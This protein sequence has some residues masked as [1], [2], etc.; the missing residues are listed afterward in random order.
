MEKRPQNIT[1]FVIDSNVLMRQILSSMLS[2]ETGVAISGSTGDYDPDIISSKITLHQPDLLFLGVERLHSDEMKLFYHLRNEFPDTHIVL[3]THLNYEGAAVALQGLKNGAIDYV[4]KPD[5]KS[6]IFADSHFHKRV[7]PLLKALAKLNRKGERDTSF[8]PPVSRVSKEFFPNVGRMKPEKIDLVVIGSCMG[9]VSSIYKI[10]PALPK[11]LSVPVFIVQH[12][13]RIYTEVFAK[14]LDKITPLK[15]L[16]AQDKSEMV[17]GSIYVAPGGRHSVIKNECGRKRIELHKGPRVHKCR[18]S[19][20]VMLRSAV[21]EFNGKILGVFLSGGGNDGALGAL[22]ILEHGG[23]ILLES[24]E[25]ALIS[26]LAEKV[27]IL[28][29]NI[30]EVSAGAMSSEIVDHINSVSQH[31]KYRFAQQTF[32]SSGSYTG[33]LEA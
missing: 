31:K 14:D 25:S 15:V 20:D 23:T 13:P 21:Q 16:E 12:M 6:L 32:N 19:I 22:K 27:K 9:G 1:V 5:N 18:P 7:I 10:L 2:K 17:P 26:D 30:K 3:L 8:T 4:T 24:R 11:S 28:N 29:S 33:S